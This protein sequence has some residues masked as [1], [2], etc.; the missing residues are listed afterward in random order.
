[1]NPV[2][3]DEAQNEM[4]SQVFEDLPARVNRAVRPM[5]R[6]RIKCERSGSSRAQVE[7]FY[8][9]LGI[10]ASLRDEVIQELLELHHGWTFELGVRVR[11]GDEAVFTRFLVQSNLGPPGSEFAAPAYVHAGVGEVHCFDCLGNMT[12]LSVF[13]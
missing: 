2:R 1:M 5:S 13:F 3:F 11:A 7:L 8:L 6:W 12:I 9:K 10:D 4:A